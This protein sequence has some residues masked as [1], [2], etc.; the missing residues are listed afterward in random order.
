MKSRQVKAKKSFGQHF[1][2]NTQAAQKIADSTSDFGCKNVLEIG[3][4]MGALTKYLL[5]KKFNLK[6]LKI[7]K[8][9]YFE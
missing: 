1:L 6:V 2:N 9:V 4:G 5:P 8:I 3:P 7:K